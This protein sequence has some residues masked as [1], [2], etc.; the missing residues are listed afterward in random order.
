MKRTKKLLSLLLVMILALTSVPL[1]GCGRSTKEPITLTVYS[2]RANYSGEQV[3]WFAKVMLDKFNVK[4]KIVKEEQGIF[5]TRM[6]SGNLGDIIIFG[7]D[8]DKYLEAANKGMLLDWNEDNILSDYGSY[9]KK[10]MK[11]ALQKNASLTKSGKV[12]GFGYD[13]SPTA[14]DHASFIYGPY[15]RWD[16]Y[17]QLGYPKV[18]TLEDWI[19]VLKSM[20]KIC[21]K[22]D[23]GKE[24]YGV[25]LFNDWDS[26]SVMFVKATAALYGYDEFGMG[27]YNGN[28]QTWKG[29]LDNDSMYLRML[30]FYNKLFQNDLVDPD[31][32]TQKADGAGE[33]Y[34]D[35]TA[36][37]TLF[38]YLGSIQYNTDKHLK[39]GKAMYAYAMNDQDT[40]CYGLNVYGG[41]SVWTIGANSQ[42]PE[43]CM[44]IINWLCTPEGK[45]INDNGPKGV[46]W[47]YN[48]KK[49]PYL[50][51]LGLK[52]KRSG[53]TEMSDGYTGNYNDG[54]NTMNSITWDPDSV[55]P[56]SDGE[57]Y[58][59]QNW[60]TYN[61]QI[62]KID[63]LTDWRKHTGATTVNEYL[64]NHKHTVFP[65]TT[66]SLE[67]RSESLDVIWKQ[68]TK[69]IRDYTWKAIYA[70]NDAEFNSIVKEMQ[71]K[72]KG[73]GYDKCCEFMQDQAA[74]RKAAEDKVLG[75]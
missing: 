23:S 21:P 56:D 37:F 12:Y 35:G 6:E 62:N 25:S 63:I 61:A 18:K 64:Q 7:D 55:N 73:Y 24:T 52:C 60:V 67:K 42:Y 15:V 70:K 17:K 53:K 13:V 5:T 20:K 9:I 54:M 32:L 1:T 19:P 50:T 71:K 11:L 39:A 27:L 51:A 36:F 14:K 72:A 3:G 59:Y 26:D 66:F 41:N 65:A 8:N 10:H 31:S 75:K 30:K 47:N 48:S 38:D 43:L 33:D 28:T 2:Q 57:T 40:I 4:L 44:K 69:I 49:Q 74:K 34:T 29:N 16:L 68:V 58:N 22:S 46:T 45:M